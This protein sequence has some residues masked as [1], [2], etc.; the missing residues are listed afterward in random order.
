MKIAQSLKPSVRGEYE[1][2]D[3]NKVYLSDGSLSYEVINCDWYDAGDVDKLLK[4][5]ETVFNY[6]DRTGVQVA[7]IEEIALRNGWIS[8]KSV[9]RLAQKYNNRYGDYLKALGY[10]G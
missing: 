7:C 6:Q 9:R 2:T 1:I 8:E 5:S 10:G 3:V 4:A